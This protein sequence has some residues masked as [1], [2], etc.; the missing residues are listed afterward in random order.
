MAASVLQE[1]LFD[2]IRTKDKNMQVVS[3][4]VENEHDDFG[5]VQRVSVQEIK[6]I[7]SF[8]SSFSAI[9]RL[10]PCARSEKQVF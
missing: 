7:W 8:E 10:C 9:N 2:A 5:N 3:A 6:P 1:D 4:H